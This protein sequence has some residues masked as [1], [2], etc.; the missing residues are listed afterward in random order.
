MILD[1]ELVSCHQPV[2]IVA[3]IIQKKERIDKGKT[4]NKYDSKLDPRYKKYIM[5]A[6]RKQIA[7]E[8]TESEFKT[9]TSLNC[10]YCGTSSRIGIDRIDSKGGYTRDNVRPCCTKCNMMKYTYSEQEFISHMQ[11]II[12]HLGSS[13]NTI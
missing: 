8:L 1:E 13:L 9:I 4:R 11:K 7:M 2:P 10:Y 6:N 5:R 3:P 12:K